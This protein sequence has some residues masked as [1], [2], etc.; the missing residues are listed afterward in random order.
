MAVLNT[1][2]VF[3]PPEPKALLRHVHRLATTA[4]LNKQSSATFELSSQQERARL[5]VNGTQFLILTDEF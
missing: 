2:I 4:A 3:L 5:L 1:R